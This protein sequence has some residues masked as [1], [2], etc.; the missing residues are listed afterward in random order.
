MARIS[1]RKKLAIKP[2]VVNADIEAK[3]CYNLNLPNGETAQI[4]Y[5]E[6]EGPTLHVEMW[7]GDDKTYLQVRGSER[8][9]NAIDLR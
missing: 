5:D 7:P 6:D 8:F 9:V 1:R 2:E 3:V 4:I